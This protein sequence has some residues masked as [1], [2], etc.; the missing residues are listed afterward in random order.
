MDRGDDYAAAGFLGRVGFGARPAV[1]VVDV[2]TAY[3]DPASPLSD[4]GGRFEKARAAGAELV[5][6]ARAHD[7]PVLFTEVRLGA[8]GLDGGHFRR[9]V[10]AL[11]AFEPGS[12]WAAFPDAPAPLPGEVVVT[13][14]YA[15]AFFGTSLASTLRFLG[16]DTVLVVGF[17]TSG[18]VRAT[19]TDALQHGFRPIVVDEAC[20]D[21]D[22]QVHEQNLF[23]LDAKYADVVS[24]ADAVAHL[25][26]PTSTPQ[27]RSSAVIEQDLYDETLKWTSFAPA[28]ADQKAEMAM[29]RSSADGTSRTVLVRFPEGW[30]RAMTGHQ[31]AGEEMLVLEGALSMSGHTCR[32]GALLVV[33]PRATRSETGTEV[34]TRAVV[35]FSGAAGGWTEGPSDDAGT[36][37]VHELA[38]GVVRPAGGVLPGS[39]E[40]LDG[41]D[42]TTFPSDVDLCWTSERCWAHVPAGETAPRHDGPVVVRHWA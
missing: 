41:A 24:L 19:A 31:P 18:C 16:V 36:L 1:V 21:R 7:V 27:T 10:P 14:Q 32:P 22:A 35:W 25:R 8:D 37:G 28:G 33:E 30:K 3:L 34:E 11:A 4:A 13:K 2:V 23:D 9:K 20:G 42:L 40:V 6:V 26:T 17:S 12:P 29:L 39:V 5:D 38:P 15:S